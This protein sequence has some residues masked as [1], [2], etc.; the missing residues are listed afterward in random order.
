MNLEKIDPKT[1]EFNNKLQVYRA[2]PQGFL[3]S[4]ILRN[5]ISDN[6]CYMARTGNGGTFV[7]NDLL[8]GLGYGRDW[9]GL[10]DSKRIA[11]P[12]TKYVALL[13][14]NVQP[15]LD[16]LH[17]DTSGNEGIV[18]SGPIALRDLVVLFGAEKNS[19]SQLDLDQVLLAS[20]SKRD[21]FELRKADLLEMAAEPLLD[22]FVSRYYRSPEALIQQIY[23]YLQKQAP[24]S[25]EEIAELTLQ[26]IS[27]LNQ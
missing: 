11:P 4:D 10:L 22:T 20:R 5:S 14:I 12:F 8:K 24:K 27:L 16:R 23:T 21:L 7:T 3:E 13:G 9:S 18:I 26:V 19:L 25:R 2:I 1:V 15:Y 17:R 6:H